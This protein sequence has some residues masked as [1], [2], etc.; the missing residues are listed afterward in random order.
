MKL[1]NIY[2]LYKNLNDLYDLKNDIENLWK[3]ENKIEDVLNLD[4]FIVK[5]NIA[6]YIYLKD[7]KTSIPYN[8]VKGKKSTYFIYTA[9]GNS[10]E[11]FNE[12]LDIFKKN[13][14]NIE[15]F[16]KYTNTDIITKMIDIS[17]GS[18]IIYQNEYYLVK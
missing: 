2:T 13:K 1:L 7:G 15:N 8:I 10:E 4:E 12:F 5:L 18:Y 14:Y 6:K 11:S 9:D 17:K 16:K 3:D